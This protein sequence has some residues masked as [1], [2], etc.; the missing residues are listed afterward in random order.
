[1]WSNFSGK[2]VEKAYS[3]HWHD[4]LVPRFPFPASAL[5]KPYP[6]RLVTVNCTIFLCT[7]DFKFL[8]MT[9]RL[10][11]SMAGI[12]CP[13]LK[14]YIWELIVD[15]VRTGFSDRSGNSGYASVDDTGAAVLQ[16]TDELSCAT[17]EKLLWP[18]AI[19][20]KSV[21]S[22]LQPLLCVFKKSKVLTR[23]Q[24]F[25]KYAVIITFV[26]LQYNALWM[27]VLVPIGFV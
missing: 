14:V 26:A 11:S 6:T 13:K 27:I 1:M 24:N 17:A 22:S 8:Q 10:C 20:V 25:F 4:C 23:K 19:L 5:T 3:Y 7:P 18:V 2:A 15:R 16:G 21:A 12:M 9:G